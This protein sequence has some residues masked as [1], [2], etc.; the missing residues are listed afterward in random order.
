MLWSNTNHPAACATTLIVAL[1]LM[2]TL[3]EVT[4]IVISVALLVIFHNTIVDHV[5]ELYGVKPEDPR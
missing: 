2:S 5:Q 4:I 1:G 3:L